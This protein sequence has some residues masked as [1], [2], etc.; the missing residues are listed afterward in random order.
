MTE[1]VILV[2][3]DHRQVR[4]SLVQVLQP[5]FRSVKGISNPNL[6]PSELESY[7][8]DVV[9][10][11]MNFSAGINSGNEGLYWLREIKARSP[12]TEVITITAYGE[13]DLAVKAMREGSFDF[14][15]KP[16][17]NTKL[18][19]TITNALRFKNSQQQV[20]SL[21]KRQDDLVSLFNS[22]TE[23]MLGNSAS[24]AR[25]MEM[26]ARVAPTDANILI[27]GENGTGKGLLARMIHN[28]SGRSG[29]PFVTVDLGSL[30]ETLFESELFGHK[31][32]AFTDAM[33]ERQGRFMIADSGTLFLDEVANIPVHLQGK[34]LTVI[35]ERMV[36][37]LGSG[38]PETTDIRLICATNRRLE[39]M[40]RNNLFREDLYFRINTIE[41]K[42][43]PLRERMEDLPM[44][45]DHYLACFASRYGK[46]GL[47][48]T[49]DAWDQ[50]NAYSWPGNIRELRH[51]IEK[52]V[53][54]SNGSAVT[55]GDL[56]INLS[57]NTN[58]EGN[59][60]EDIEKRAIFSTLARYGGNI[61][62]AAAELKVSRQTLYNKI[63][64]YGPGYSGDYV[65]K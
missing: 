46:K 63:E 15:Q 3:E 39:E 31:K 62:E 30:P 29:R 14:I 43:P 33:N 45:A 27:T 35:Q 40:V 58:R 38:R 49:S 50:L 54:L 60:L 10:L 36:T 52:G 64:K 24:M 42:L 25:L 23:P 56:C 5:G 4:E 11:D 47:R 17:E 61:R 32:G 51:Q 2:V 1:A 65:Q 21:K 26:V 44:L 37:P 13:I 53:I 41:L 18:V 20:S 19:T 16:W 9:L 59:S 12:A 8:P 22:D 55:A 6:I 7:N 57:G 34:L 28:M 48:L